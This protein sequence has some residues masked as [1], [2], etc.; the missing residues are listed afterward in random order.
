MVRPSESVTCVLPLVSTRHRRAARWGNVRVVAGVPAEKTVLNVCPVASSVKVSPK[1][2][3][4]ESGS[5]TTFTVPVVGAAV[6]GV[7]CV[8]VGDCVVGGGGFAVVGGV[9]VAGG[10]VVTVEVTADV[11]VIGNVVATGSVVAATA[12]VVVVSAVA[13]AVTAAPSSPQAAIATARVSPPRTRRTATP[14]PYPAHVL[15]APPR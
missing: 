6:V 10:T 11:V 7:D 8:V 3:W 13:A 12:L 2:D 9:V 5:Q 1:P 4:S 14:T 15:D